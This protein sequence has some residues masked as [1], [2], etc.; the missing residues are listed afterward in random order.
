M[1]QLILSMIVAVQSPA[2][3]LPVITIDRDNVEITESCVIQIGANPII[4]ADD[5]GVIHI[6]RGGITVDFNGQHLHGATADQTPD[7]FSGV[8]VKI[9]AKDVTLKDAKVAGYKVGIHAIN[10]DGLT[11]HD[12]DVSNNYHRRLKSTPQAEDGSDW[13]WPHNNDNNEWMT[14]YGAGICVEDSNNVTLHDIRARKTQNGLLLDCVNESKVYDCD[15]SFLSGW[16]LAMWRSSKNVISRN[17]FDFCVRGYS[18]GV[19]NR[20]QD[21]AGILMFEQCC[22]NVIAENSATHCGDGVFAFAGKEALGEVNQREDLEWCKHR[23]CN[24]N[25][26]AENDFSFA[27]AHGL[28]ITFS[29][30]NQIWKNKFTGNAICGIWGGYS[31]STVIAENH[32]DRNGEMAYGLERGG[33]NIEH[34]QRNWIWS[35]QFTNNSCGIHL[36]WDEDAGIA[37]SAWAKANSVKSTQN[38]IA[39]NEF[40]SDLIGLQLRQSTH[41]LGFLNTFEGLNQDIVADADSLASL[42]LKVGGSIGLPGNPNYVAIGNKR[43]VQQ[44]Q[45]LAGRENIIMTEWGPWD[46]ESPLLR[47]ER[48]FDHAH[49]YKL[50]G[51]KKM[52]STEAIHIEG[53]IDV[54][55]RDDVIR[56]QAKLD[57]TLIPYAISVE[58]DGEQVNAKGIVSTGRW[59]VWTFKSA[60]DP[61]EDVERWRRDGAAEHHTLTADT[62]DFRFGSGGMS[63]ARGLPVPLPT[64][65]F[66]VIATRSL[67]IPARKWRLK[68]TSDDGIRVWMDDQLVIDDWTWHG[69]TKHDYEFEVKDAREHNFRIE[70]FE[71]DGYAVLSL[72]FE[73]I[74]NR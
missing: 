17:A 61:R 34:G 15:C 6:S 2:P 42:D 4:D 31:G 5:N 8:G 49:E 26:F 9:N 70:Y 22:D 40:K 36:W 38:W 46:H 18:H 59:E 44:R 71:L 56:V 19:Y 57:K 12:C 24:R 10:A 47:F 48:W 35:N 67:T 72:D 21:S 69:P 58:A 63:Q 20:G 73:R 53:D 50:L 37:T 68:T 60:C 64:D 52:P 43:A 32:F 62:I 30:D 25:V 13:L 7:T 27:P 11:I 45:D 51:V 29:F 28:E 3:P 66:G 55:V 16:G 65:H 41:T 74:D 54:E 14:D 23:G 39:E 1:Y 33:V